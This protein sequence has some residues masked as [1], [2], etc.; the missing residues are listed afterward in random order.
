[1]PNESDGFE[2]RTIE[3]LAHGGRGAIKIGPFGS[4]LRKEEMQTSGVKVYG[5]ENIILSDWAAGERRVSASKAAALASCRLEP[6]DVVLTMMGTVGRCD[7]FPLDAEPGIMDSHLLRIQPDSAVLDR[8]FL[9]KVI[10]DPRAVGRQVDQLSHGSIMAGLSSKIVRQL[11]LPVPPLPE[12]RRITEILDTLDEA[13]RKSEQVITKLQHIRRGLLHDLLT[14]GIDENGA[15]RDPDRH[16][17][18]FQDSPLGRIPKTWQTTVVG[19]LLLGEIDYRG[20]T[21]TKIGMSWGDGDVP[22]LSA[23]NVRDGGIDLSLETY[24][25]SQA[26]YERWMTKGHA[27]KGDVLI[28]MEAPLGNIAQIPDERLYILS[29][30]VVLLK[31]DAERASNDFMAIQMRHTMFQ[32]NLKRWST[33]TTATGIQRARLVRVPVAV[34]PPREQEI[35]VSRAHS[36]EEQITTETRLLEKLRDLKYGLTVDLLTGHV[37]VRVPEEVAT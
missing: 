33:G 14:R 16:S 4:Q 15:L 25:G 10:S 22:A 35:V 8:H 9:A 7:V 20:R 27:S 29:Q 13:I 6:G 36:V 24:Y 2:Q 34:P 12:Q 23:K 18:H 28:T 11:R 30:R 17:E 5:Q 19:E 31:F 21:P 1:M 32:A 3:Q 37:R 26:L